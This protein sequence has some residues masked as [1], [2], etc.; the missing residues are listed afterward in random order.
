MKHRAGQRRRGDSANSADYH[1]LFVIRVHELLKLGYDRLNPRNYAKSDEPSLTQALVQTMDD[2]LEDPPEAIEAWCDFFHVS[3]DPPENT[4]GLRG[5]RRKRVD[6]RVCSGQRP[7]R[8]FRFE[9]K[10]LNSPKSVTSYIGAAGL[11][12]YLSEDYAAEDDEAGMLGYVQVDDES[13]WAARLKDCFANEPL[14]TRISGPGQWR[15]HNLTHGP[16]HTYHTVHQRDSGR[17]IGIFHTLLR[18]C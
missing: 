5:K 9:A 8:R 10:R 11:G 13:V 16:S 18:F 12:C 2:V 7:R 17:N 3:D 6:V 14:R 1:R 4:K 15:P